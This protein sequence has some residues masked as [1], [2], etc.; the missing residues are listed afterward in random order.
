MLRPE[1]PV[2]MTDLQRLPPEL[3]DLRLS[4]LAG[5]HLLADQAQDNHDNADPADGPRDLADRAHQR[6]WIVRLWYHAQHGEKEYPGKTQ[7]NGAD[8]NQA[9]VSFPHDDFPVAA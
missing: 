3:N 6:G 2:T 5:R 7:Q 9:P 4:A 1:N 8:N